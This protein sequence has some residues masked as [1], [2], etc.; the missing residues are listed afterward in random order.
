MTRTLRR[1]KGASSRGNRADPPPWLI[2]IQLYRVLG[3]NFLVLYAL[4]R[5]PAEFA[6]PAGVGDV[7]VGL[8]APLEQ[9]FHAA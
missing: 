6:L 7:I 5:L 3:L 1:T 9:Q 8:A 4:G 2:G